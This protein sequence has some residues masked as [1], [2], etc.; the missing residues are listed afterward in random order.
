MKRIIMA[1][2]VL[3]VGA[4]PSFS[5][6]RG[7]GEAEFF[8]GVALLQSTTALTAEQ[9]AE[10][11]RELQRMTGITGTRAL[12]LLAKYRDKPEEWLLLNGTITKQLSGLQPSLPPADSVQKQKIQPVKENIHVRNDQ[13]IHRQ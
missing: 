5:S 8:S 11:Y 3:L 1:G 2:M 4:V 9:K 7:E 10:K 6:S 12:A 13:R